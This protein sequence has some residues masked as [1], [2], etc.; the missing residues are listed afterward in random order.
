MCRAVRDLGKQGEEVIP[1][2]IPYLGDAEV[3]VRIEAAKALVE[4]GGPEDRGRPDPGAC[5]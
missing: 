1:Q 4:I 2:V 5:R 3:S